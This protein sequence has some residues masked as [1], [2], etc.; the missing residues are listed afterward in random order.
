[1]S[2]GVGFPSTHLWE[3]STG[4]AARVLLI[5]WLDIAL[6]LSI[7][8]STSQTNITRLYTYILIFHTEDIIRNCSADISTLGLIWTSLHEGASLINEKS[9]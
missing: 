8:V 1:M 5:L 9:R 6:V 4:E 2:Q 3:A 7:R